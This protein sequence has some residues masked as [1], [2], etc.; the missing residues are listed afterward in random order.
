MKM[1][2]TICVIPILAGM[3]YSWLIFSYFK[4][5]IM[6]LIIGQVMILKLASVEGMV[7]KILND[8]FCVQ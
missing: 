7:K 3:V 5:D 6:E 2:E 1:H 4:N 8:I